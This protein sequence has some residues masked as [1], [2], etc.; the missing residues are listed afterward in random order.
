MNWATIIAVLLA[1]VATA[2][3]AVCEFTE[4]RRIQYQSYKVERRSEQ[5]ERRILRLRGSIEALTTPRRLLEHLDAPAPPATSMPMPNLG[6]P[7]VT[8]VR[9]ALSDPTPPTEVLDEAARL[10]LEESQRREEERRRTAPQSFGAGLPH[11]MQGAEHFESN[12][13]GANRSAPTRRSR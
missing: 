10:R 6:T 13:S 3:V 4:I 2:M 9:G 8:E 1:T 11:G 12:R 5:T 7:T